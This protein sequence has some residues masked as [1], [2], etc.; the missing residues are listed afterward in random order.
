MSTRVWFTTNHG[1][2][3]LLYATECWVCGIAFAWPEHLDDRARERGTTFYCP[4]GHAIRYGESEATKLRAEL[5]REEGRI[6]QLKYDLKHTEGQRRAEKAAKT[7]LKN[8]IAKGV[9]PCCNRHF[10]NV[11]RHI[12]NQHPG[13]ADSA[14]RTGDDT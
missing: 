14:G 5:A 4:N 10:A 9:C 3:T 13:F 1:T 11:Q 12:E 7:K 2:Q 6:A 8:R